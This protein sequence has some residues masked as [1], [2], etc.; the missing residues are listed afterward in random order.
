MRK[1]QE[2]EARR[3]AQDLRNKEVERARREIENIRV[4]EAKKLA[5]SLKEKG[6]L[7][8]DINVRLCFLFLEVLR[9]LL[10]V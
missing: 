7:K 6:T 8:V 1:H 5:Q 3:A 4:E 2:D 10:I 9:D